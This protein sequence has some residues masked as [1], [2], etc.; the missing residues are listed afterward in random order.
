[1]IIKRS[2]CGKLINHSILIFVGINTVKAENINWEKVNENKPSNNV[3]WE[4]FYPHDS[5]NRFKNKIKNHKEID[6]LVNLGKEKKGKPKITNIQPFFHTNNFLKRNE[7]T[8]KIIWLSSFTSGLSGGTGQQNNSYQFNYGLTENTLLTGYFSEADDYLYNEIKN[9]QKTSYSWQNYALSLKQNLINSSKTNISFVNSFEFWRLSS[10][11]DISQSI[12]SSSKSLNKER[13]NNFIYAFSFPISFNTNEKL[14][15]Y[16]IPGGS[17]LPSKYGNSNKKNS[18]GNNFFIGTGFTYDIANN[19]SFLSSYS[20]LLG[21]GD[22]YF[23]KDLIYSRKNIYSLGFTFSSSPKIEIE[24]KITNGFGGTPATSILTLPSTNKP[25]YYAGIKINHGEEDIKFKKFKNSDNVLRFGGI[26]VSNS[27][28]PRL[29]EK[30]LSINLDEQG[31]FFTSYGYSISNTFQL[32][33]INIGRFRNIEFNSNKNSTTKDKFISDGNTNYRIGGK[34]LIFSPMKGDSI[35]LSSRISVG[36][37]DTNNQGYIFSEIIN[38]FKF[39]EKLFFNINP[40]HYWSG[41]E[42]FS[43]LGVSLNYIFHEKYSLLSEI[44]FNLSN[45]DDN[46]STFSIRYSPN[47]KRNYD[48]I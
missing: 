32:E 27:Y 21:P 28:L 11:S 35:W 46:N 45:M 8:S 34:F 20:Y 42:S 30:S 43:G 25:L 5:E 13:F 44:N 48:F 29:Y 16:F 15:L 12:Y 1:M 9:N 24:G 7:I 31:N 19:L 37:N 40:K 6:D 3:I 33:L 22:N 23:D 2:N 18:Y 14:S 38:T 17:F 47:K 26:T 39:H 10:G 41:F 4:I 36:R